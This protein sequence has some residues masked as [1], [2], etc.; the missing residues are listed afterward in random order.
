MRFVRAPLLVFGV[1]L[2]FQFAQLKINSVFIGF[3]CQVECSMFR[4]TF[5]PSISCTWLDSSGLT[6]GGRLGSSDHGFRVGIIVRPYMYCTCDSPRCVDAVSEM[7][8]IFPS[9]PT[10][11]MKPSRL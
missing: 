4:D 6:T 8:M 11:K 10:T 9:T 3:N 1:A 2:Y 5:T 7:Y